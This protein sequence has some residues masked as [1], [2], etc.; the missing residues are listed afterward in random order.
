MTLLKRNTFRSEKGLFH[1]RW[2]SRS[3]GNRIV[4]LGCFLIGGIEASRD[5]NLHMPNQ[6]TKLLSNQKSKMGG[7][8]CIPPRM[9]AFRVQLHS[10]PIG[11]SPG[12][13]LPLRTASRMEEGVAS[14]INSNT[15]QIM[16]NAKRD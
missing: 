8:K 1:Q 3:G 14:Q 5:L 12:L 11:K 16:L 10:P 7:N 6:R 9:L 15:R 13:H 4:W 2:I